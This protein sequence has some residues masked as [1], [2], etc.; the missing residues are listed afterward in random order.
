[1]IQQSVKS[2]TEDRAVDSSSS[3][4][5]TTLSKPTLTT[6]T[7]ATEAK[8]VVKKPAVTQALSDSDKEAARR[9]AAL[10]LRKSSV[11]VVSDRR[12]V[13]SSSAPTASGPALSGTMSSAPNTASNMRPKRPHEDDNS[14]PAAK[15]FRLLAND[16]TLKEIFNH[17]RIH[18]PD[19]KT[20]YGNATMIHVSWVGLNRLIFFLKTIED[21][22]F[23]T[24]NIQVVDESSEPVAPTPEKLLRKILSLDMEPSTDLRK[25]KTAMMQLQVYIKTIRDS[26][27][28]RTSHFNISLE[29][30]HFERISDVGDIM[31]KDT[32]SYKKNNLHCRQANLEDCITPSSFQCIL[33]SDAPVKEY[34]PRDGKARSL[35]HFGQRK[36]LLSEIQ[37]LTHFLQPGQLVVYAGAAPGTHLGFLAEMFPE[38]SFV[39]I[40]HRE[41]TIKEPN[42]RLTIVAE[43]FSDRHALEYAN[44]NVLFICDHRS[45]D[46]QMDSPEE[47]ERKTQ[48]DMDQ[49]MAWHYIIS[50]AASMFRFRPPYAYRPGKTTFFDGIVLL[51]VWGRAQTTESSLV[52]LREGKKRDWDNVVYERQM[53]HFNTEVRVSAFPNDLEASS[54]DH[55]FD[56]TAESFIVREVLLRRPSLMKL[57]AEQSK[58]WGYVANNVEK[59]LAKGKSE[60]CCIDFLVSP[61]PDTYLQDVEQFRR[62]VEA[63]V[64]LP[65]H[66]IIGKIPYV[67]EDAPSIPVPSIPMIPPAAGYDTLA[68]LSEASEAMSMPPPP[69]P[70][71][72]PT[73]LS[74]TRLSFP[75]PFIV[76]EQMHYSFEQR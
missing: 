24:N 4:S 47:V 15:R 63:G 50:P 61:Q 73:P 54:M 29:H 20:W 31:T 68:L 76:Q 71:A 5:L 40:D 67:T 37:F 52:V 7:S 6:S 66:R 75:K 33:Y 46:P 18:E 48:N 21:R 51:P 60:G 3:L 65:A 2:Q 27:L 72:P 69:P 43:Q 13:G 70:I 58:Q 56:C 25:L 34:A 41:F 44:K 49:Q 9:Q 57:A 35:Q 32:W 64:P 17:L 30:V 26:I 39:L 19:T 45:A 38:A 12:G 10:I 28:R 1:M 74:G 62:D 42:P 23:K 11:G 14:D 53:Y 59:V 36:L 55:C 16:A 8:K 22:R